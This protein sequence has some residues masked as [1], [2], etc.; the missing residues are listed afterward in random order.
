MATTVT[1][2]S[3]AQWANCVSGEFVHCLGMYNSMSTCLFKYGCIRCMC[4][5]LCKYILLFLLP[6]FFFFKLS[7]IVDCLTVRD[8]VWC[9][10]AAQN[11]KWSMEQC[12]NVSMLR[13]FGFVCL[14]LTIVG[15]YFFLC[16]LLYQLMRSPP[17]LWDPVERS[18]R[19]SSPGCRHY[20]LNPNREF[21]SEKMLSGIF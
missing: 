3:P 8:G 4:E 18:S 9:Q 19:I 2:L 20:K 17:G 14:F 6:F 21:I 1:D 12:L 13:F 5:Y 11:T 16:V 7:G 15:F 10:S